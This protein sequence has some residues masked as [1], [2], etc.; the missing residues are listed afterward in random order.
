MLLQ[1]LSFVQTANKS[2]KLEQ[3]SLKLVLNA[4]PIIIVVKNA[5]RKLG[6]K[7]LMLICNRKLNLGLLVK[8][9]NCQLF[10][11]V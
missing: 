4:F 1:F 8:K 9:V 10:K 5:R 7:M 6:Q 2:I 3:L 11:L